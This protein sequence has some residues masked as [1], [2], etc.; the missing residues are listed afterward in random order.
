MRA[1]LSDMGF[2]L[3]KSRTVK[4]SRKVPIAWAA[5]EVFSNEYH[6]GS[7]I[8]RYLFINFARSE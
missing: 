3:C 2:I 6:S 5:P 1:K 7:D 8:W 4:T